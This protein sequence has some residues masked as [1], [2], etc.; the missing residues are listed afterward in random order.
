MKTVAIFA[1]G[2]ALGVAGVLAFQNPRKVGSVAKSGVDVVQARV[3]EVQRSQCTEDFLAESHCF[4]KRSA[5][6]C[7][8]LIVKRCGLPNGAK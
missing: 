6:E 2:L 3:E 7:D 1:L 4:Q 8:A 5:K